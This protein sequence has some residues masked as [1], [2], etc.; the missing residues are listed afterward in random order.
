MGNCTYCGKPAGLLRSA[1]KECEAENKR[2][3]TIAA[4]GEGQ[5]VS[6]IESAISQGRNLTQLDKTLSDVRDRGWLVRFQPGQQPVP[7]LM[8]MPMRLLIAL[9]ALLVSVQSFACDTD[10]TI[11]VTT[12]GARVLV[13]LRSGKPGNS[14]VVYSASTRGG[15]VKFSDI[16]AGNYFFAIGDAETVDVTPS[17]FI[18]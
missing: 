16:C 2:T 4:A 14:Q 18:D 13:E 3:L 5:M 1:H 11:N 10:Y 9:A 15:V 6:E 12:Y 17:E 7:I 8:R